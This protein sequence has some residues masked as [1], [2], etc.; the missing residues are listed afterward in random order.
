MVCQHLHRA[1]S[2]QQTRSTGKETSANGA[3]NSSSQVPILVLS[4]CIC[5]PYTTSSGKAQSRGC[6]LENA[7][8]EAPGM[9]ALGPLKGTF[10]LVSQREMP[11]SVLQISDTTACS[12]LFLR[13]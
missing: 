4:F 2:V 5:T 13:I 11:Q 7:T 10:H 3:G 8:L 9:A 6:Q 1:G 12:F